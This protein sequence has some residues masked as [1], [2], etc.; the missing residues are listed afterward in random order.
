M[1]RC[2]HRRSVRDAISAPPRKVTPPQLMRLRARRGRVDARKV[3]ACGRARGLGYG[4]TRATGVTGVTG[5]TVASAGAHARDDATLRDAG[6]GG[7]GC[8]HC[9][10]DRCGYAARVWPCPPRGPVVPRWRR[11]FAPACRRMSPRAPHICYRAGCHEPRGL[12]R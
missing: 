1:R 2:A 8:K 4:A 10:A 9:F 7:Y 11:R 5:V 3:C 6:Y 12:A